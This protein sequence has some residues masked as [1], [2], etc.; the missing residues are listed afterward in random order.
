MGQ[1]SSR[2][3]E[4]RSSNALVLV[5]FVLVGLVLGGCASDQRYSYWVLN[6]SDHPVLVDVHEQANTTYIV[7]PHNYGALFAGMGVPGKDWSIRLVDEA[8]APAQ[9]FDVDAV[10]SLMYVD[11][12]GQGELV[13]VPPWSHGL[14]TATSAALAQRA[15]PCP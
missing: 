9:V 14:R 7:G 10:H 2:L 3:L 6:D 15:T 4:R 12:T 13:D 11:P 5:G 8:C 1:H